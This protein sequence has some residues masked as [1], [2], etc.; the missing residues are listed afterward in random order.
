VDL[1]RT[2]EAMAEGEAPAKFFLSSLD[3]GV[4]KTQ[5]ITHF[6]DA[7]LS[8]PIHADVG[9]LICVARLSELGNLIHDMAIPEENL[10][11]VTSN[12]TLNAL[13]KAEPNRAQV[14]IITQQMI[15]KRLNCGRFSD[16]GQFFYDGSPRA[17][18]IWDESYLPVARSR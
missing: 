6:V 11:V 3:P 16:A 8:S 5:T 1:T 7:L 9:V 15:E 17:V 14:L 18:R 12:P 4:G 10:A 2:L 13:G